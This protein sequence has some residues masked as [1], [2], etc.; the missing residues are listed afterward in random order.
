MDEKFVM[1]FED[2][3]IKIK[4]FFLQ[5]LINNLPHSRQD[6]ILLLFSIKDL[7][8]NELINKSLSELLVLGEF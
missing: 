7:E 2:N 6:E 1:N 4:H 3:L 8:L 5:L